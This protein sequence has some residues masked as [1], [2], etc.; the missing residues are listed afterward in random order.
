MSNNLSQVWSA[1]H[2]SWTSSRG[3]WNDAA[4][5]RFDSQVLDPLDQQAGMVIRV[6]S[7]LDA[8]MKQADTNLKNYENQMRSL[9]QNISRLL[10][11]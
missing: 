8:F 1:A 11:G 10:Q 7:E 9:Q 2:S 6:V 5:M 3:G 4:R